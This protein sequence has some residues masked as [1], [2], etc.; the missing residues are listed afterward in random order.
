MR[1]IVKEEAKDQR[2]FTLMELLITVGIVVA[3]VGVIV[4]PW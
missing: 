2:G 1:N 3:L 4:P